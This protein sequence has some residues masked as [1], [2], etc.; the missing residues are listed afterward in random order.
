MVKAETISNIS[1]PSPGL[2]YEPETVPAK[3]LFNIVTVK[4]VLII[5]ESFIVKACL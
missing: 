5:R 4:R 1:V 2:L 3:K